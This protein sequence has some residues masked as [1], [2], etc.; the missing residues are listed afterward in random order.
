MFESNTRECLYQYKVVQVIFAEKCNNAD[1]RSYEISEVN[2][3][4]TVSNTALSILFATQ[5]IKDNDS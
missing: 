5:R 3:Q 1:Q 4:L 2:S